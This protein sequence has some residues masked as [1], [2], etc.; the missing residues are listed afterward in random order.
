MRLISFWLACLLLSVNA[1]GEELTL[2][3]G[4]T[5]QKGY[6]TAL[7]YENVSG[8]L[9]IKVT[10]R[11]KERRFILDTGAPNSISKA[12][13]NPKTLASI[14][15]SDQSNKT[16]SMQVVLMEELSLGGISFEGVPT[17]VAENPVLFG[18][19]GVDGLIGSNMLRNSIVR[20]SSVDSTIIITDDAGRLGLK[21][22]YAGE[23]FLTPTQSNPYF[24]IELK[25]KKKARQQLLFD[26]G[27]ND[28]YSVS[29]QHFDLFR[30]YGIYQIDATGTGSNSWGLHGNAGDTLQYR[31]HV[32]E[33]H[34]ANGVLRD[35]PGQTTADN[36]SRIG[37]QLLEYGIVTVDYLHRKF[38]FEPFKKKTELAE[39]SFGF[40]PTLVDGKF[41]VGIVWDETLKDKV[42]QGDQILTIEGQDYEHIEPCDLLV[43]ELPFKDKKTITVELR[44]GRTGARKS[45]TMGR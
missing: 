45:V 7:R 36:N 39:R 5:Q 35:A 25:N 6:Y 11:G 16:D 33:M 34:I 44:D 4:G 26:S 9:I 30:P 32:R 27:D 20:F 1:W 24:W 22:K 41:V 31:L 8:K 37:S 13:L 40:S 12:L 14:P 10:I 15:V 21:E 23:L 43:K 19:F 29:F 38:Y 18:C 3:Q 2:N 28:L 42:H 17:L